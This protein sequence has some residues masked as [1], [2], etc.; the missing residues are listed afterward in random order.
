MRVQRW[1]KRSLSAEPAPEGAGVCCQSRHDRTGSGWTIRR[2]S[3]ILPSWAIQ[4]ILPCCQTVKPR[5]R[6]TGMPH[7]LR[8]TRPRVGSLLTG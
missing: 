3:A 4:R 8:S 7:P 2:G 6:P 5:R 1:T